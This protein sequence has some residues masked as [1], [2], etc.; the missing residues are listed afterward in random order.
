MH[1]PPSLRS[2]STHNS[3]S[4]PHAM[5]KLCPSRSALEFLRQRRRLIAPSFERLSEVAKTR[6]LTLQMHERDRTC[7]RAIYQNEP[8]LGY[9]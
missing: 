1:E 8:H 9:A 5:R 4:Q 6:T 3:S 2:D 7:P